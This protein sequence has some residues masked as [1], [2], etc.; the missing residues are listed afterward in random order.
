[1]LLL[2]FLAQNYSLNACSHLNVWNFW[3]KPKFIM[4]SVEYNFGTLFRKS[5]ISIN[6]KPNLKADPNLNPNNV[7]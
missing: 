3:I 5:T 2:F 1:M 4:K 6:P 7:S